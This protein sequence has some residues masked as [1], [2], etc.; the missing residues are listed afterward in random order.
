MNAAAT[1]DSRDQAIT[2]EYTPG[3]VRMEG[4]GFRV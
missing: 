2:L 4:G 1:T 3:K